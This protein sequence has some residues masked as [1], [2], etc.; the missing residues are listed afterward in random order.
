M[1]PKRINI[2]YYAFIDSVTK[3]TTRVGNHDNLNM[4]IQTV[5]T[6][7]VVVDVVLHVSNNTLALDALN[8][9][10]NQGSP[11]IWVLPRQ[12]PACIRLLYN[13]DAGK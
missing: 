9:W 11:K 2:K 12:V 5:V 7:L 8:G 10:L 4:H 1:I 3:R 13:I 6:C